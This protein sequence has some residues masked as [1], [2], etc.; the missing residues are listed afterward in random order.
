MVVIVAVS[1]VLEGQLSGYVFFWD[2]E[3][4][5]LRIGRVKPYVQHTQIRN[6]KTS[7]VVSIFFFVILI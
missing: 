5:V 1:G 3:H 2:C 4:Y 7:T 6:T